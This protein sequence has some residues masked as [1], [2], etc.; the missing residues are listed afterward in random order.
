MLL[1]K[2]WRKITVVNPAAATPAIFWHNAQIRKITATIKTITP[3][4][5]TTCIGTE[6]KEAMFVSAYLTSDLVDHFD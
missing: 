6:V 2:H 4:T 3:N 1:V 5:V